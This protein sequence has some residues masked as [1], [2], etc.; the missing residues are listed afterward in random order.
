MK[1]MN[2]MLYTVFAFQIALIGLFAG[3]NVD[4][5]KNNI[6]RHPEVGDFSTEPNLGK[7]FII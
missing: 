4:W 7:T 2:K 1:K 6:E 5:T 3:L